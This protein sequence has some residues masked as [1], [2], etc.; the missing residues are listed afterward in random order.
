MDKNNYWIGPY[1]VYVPNDII[2]VIAED[3]HNST[4]KYGGTT[5][6]GRFGC[7]EMTKEIYLNSYAKYDKN[8]E[9]YIY[10]GNQ[11]SSNLFSNC[12]IL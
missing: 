3:G 11:K 10:T 4:S 5:E 9:V 7:I 1:G 2:H 6:R 8:Y 12:N